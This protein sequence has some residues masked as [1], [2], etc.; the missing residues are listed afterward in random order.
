MIPM[1]GRRLFWSCHCCNHPVSAWS[2]EAI[3]AAMDD[4]AAYINCTADRETD[5]HFDEV[6][7]DR[8]LTV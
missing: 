3:Q 4:H 8:A 1:L 2:Q 6:R 5:P 7:I